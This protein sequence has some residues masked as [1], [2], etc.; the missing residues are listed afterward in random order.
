M[1]REQYMAKS[2]SHPISTR[3]SNISPRA[4]CQRADIGRGLIW[5]VIQILP[6]IILYLLYMYEI[7]RDVY[8]KNNVITDTE[9][10]NGYAVQ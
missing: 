3:D 4:E 1:N 6:C 2:A 5:D 7:K 8:K 10:L 9:V